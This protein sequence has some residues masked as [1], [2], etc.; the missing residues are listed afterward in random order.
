MWCAPYHG[1]PRVYET[2]IRM[3]SALNSADCVTFLSE[4]G[5]TCRKQATKITHLGNVWSM[6]KPSNERNPAVREFTVRVKSMSGDYYA[7]KT[8]P[9]TC[10]T[11]V[12]GGNQDAA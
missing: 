2:A 10:G 3:V 9:F 6:P 12:C 4:S 5:A 7:Q 11:G 8:I 1:T